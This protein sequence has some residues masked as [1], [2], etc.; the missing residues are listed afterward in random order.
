MAVAPA[1]RGELT[2]SR[3]R[4]F[5]EIRGLAVGSAEERV[6]PLRRYLPEDSTEP[7]PQHARIVC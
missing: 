5:L 4:F 2:G 1:R 6:A 3:D 7:Q